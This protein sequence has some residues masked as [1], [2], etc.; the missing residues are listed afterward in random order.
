MKLNE[1]QRNLLDCNKRTRS[2][3][4]PVYTQARNQARIAVEDRKAMKQLNESL[5]LTLS[6]D[7]V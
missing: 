2:G 5:E 6:T 3:R 4:L 1:K 7:F